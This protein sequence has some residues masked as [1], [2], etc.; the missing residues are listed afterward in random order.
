MVFILMLVMLFTSH[1]LDAAQVVKVFD[2]PI[3]MAEIID[4]NN[5]ATL[6]E[7]GDIAICNRNNEIAS[8]INRNASL[9]KVINKGKFAVISAENIYLY[10]ANDL[11]K[12]N[13]Q[14][15]HTIRTGLIITA[16]T[17]QGDWIYFGTNTGSTHK[18]RVNETTTSLIPGTC[19][20]K[21]TGLAV[22]NDMLIVTS[23]AEY[24]KLI[25]LHTGF[26]EGILVPGRDSKQ[27]LNPTR[28]IA[29]D[30]GYWSMDV[31][32]AQ[33]NEILIYNASANG[34]TSIRRLPT[35][36]YDLG[37]PVLSVGFSGG[38]FILAGLH[39]NTAKFIDTQRTDNKGSPVIVARTDYTAGSVI[40]LMARADG[41]ILLGAGR[42]LYAEASSGAGKITLVTATDL[43]AARQVTLVLKYDD[44]DKTEIKKEFRFPPYSNVSNE[45]VVPEGTALVSTNDPNVVI[46]IE[47]K[48]ITVDGAVPVSLKLR[49]IEPEEPEKPKP[50]VL[51]VP[52]LP[53]IAADFLEYTDKYLVSIH[54]N[55]L[56]VSEKNSCRI[57]PLSAVPYLAGTDR[58]KVLTALTNRLSVYSCSNGEALYNIP[59]ADKL[60]RL[61]Y[62]NDIIAAATAA[63]TVTVISKDKVTAKITLENEITAIDLTGDGRLI[64]TATGRMFRLF[65][66]QTG[67]EIPLHATPRRFP[68]THVAFSA[69]S[70]EYPSAR[71]FITVTADGAAKLHDG[72]SGIELKG[73]NLGQIDYINFNGTDKLI[74]RDTAKNK[75]RCIN[76]ISGTELY[77]VDIEG[78]VFAILPQE[79]AAFVNVSKQTVLRKKGD[80]SVKIGLTEKNEWY[81]ISRGNYPVQFQASESL[82][83]LFTA[84]DGRTL[85][86]EEIKIYKTAALPLP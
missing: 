48:T 37:A 68:I 53:L 11:N 44:K 10:N 63:N 14:P 51:Q 56:L 16:I 55:Q 81:F 43:K 8:R 54:R 27:V 3:I 60:T 70:H 21:I 1:N 42:N 69:P 7:N 13:P 82:V 36:R 23:F 34:D 77:N 38:R 22:K 65:N 73:F 47:D 29:F 25:N 50:I 79:T 35:R 84:D 17:S 5:Y 4:D 86:P 80:D 62:R 24:P 15:Y 58:G 67:E 6:L 19:K 2:S 78:S 61:A 45:W 33:G 59:F 71:Y 57:I 30:P 64:L 39:N 9:I 20:T 83:P 40:T 46:E 18:V 32:V 85:S 12:P 28:A 75:V 76:L 31:A 49:I 66:A 74:T 26:S 41:G 52:S 72:I